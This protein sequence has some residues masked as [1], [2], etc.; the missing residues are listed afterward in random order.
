MAPPDIVNTLPVVECL[1]PKSFAQSASEYPSSLSH[2]DLYC[3]VKSIVPL[4]YQKTLFTA[5][6]CAWVGA[7]LNI[8][9]FQQQML[10]QGK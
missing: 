3:R 5:V 6:K 1:S 7:A 8:I 9:F 10:Y 4:R 2:V